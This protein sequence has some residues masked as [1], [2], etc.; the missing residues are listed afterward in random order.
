MGQEKAKQRVNGASEN[1]VFTEWPNVD[2]E[3]SKLG[4]A[5]RNTERTKRAK[6]AA[7]ADD[8]TRRNQT[9]QQSS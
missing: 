3:S 1:A 5:L 6:A 2:V 7:P 9:K 8:R 4:D